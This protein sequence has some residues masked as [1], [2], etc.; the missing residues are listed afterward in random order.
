[1]RCRRTFMKSSI[2]SAKVG[3][4]CSGVFFVLRCCMPSAPYQFCSLICPLPLV[5]LSKAARARQRRRSTSY[6][7]L[8]G[9]VEHN[10]D[11]IEGHVN[12]C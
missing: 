9:V 10:Y 7:R 4:D 8:T 6:R 1:M 2:V 12:I 3:I 11:V 5:V